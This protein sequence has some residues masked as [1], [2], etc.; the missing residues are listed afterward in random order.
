MTGYS[1]I[2]GWPARALAAGLVLLLGGIPAQAQTPASRKARPLRVTGPLAEAP[3]GQM[4]VVYIPEASRVMA[5]I[6]ALLAVTHLE[7][8]QNPLRRWLA[9]LSLGQELGPN[10]ELTFCIGPPPRLGGRLTRATLVSGLDTGRVVGRNEANDGGIYV[11]QGAPDVMLLD[12]PTVAL[13]GGESLRAIAAA[14]RGIGL[15]VRQREVLADADVLVQLDL[16]GWLSHLEPKYQAARAAFAARAAEARREA[17]DSDEA[18]AELAMVE[19]RLKAAESLWARLHE[20]RAVTFGLMVGRRA[21][22][23]RMHLSVVAGSP[24]ARALAGHPALAG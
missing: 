10:S 22:G 12:G 6:D 17:E 13:G 5:R 14:R 18:A 2:F 8:S 23:L 19:R 16:A 21:V 1:V 20:L 15:T 4:L 11:R 24:L 7:P 3:A 9:G